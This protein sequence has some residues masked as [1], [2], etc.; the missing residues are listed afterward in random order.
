[1]PRKKIEDGLTNQQR[2]YR[3]HQAERRAKAR[4]KYQENKIQIA[5]IGK[6]DRKGWAPE[7]K[8]AVYLAGVKSMVHNRGVAGYRLFMI[9]CGAKRRAKLAGLPFNL[10]EADLGKPPVICPVLGIPIIYMEPHEGN[11]PQDNSPS[12]DRIKPALGYVRGNIRII[13][14]RANRLRNNA[15][16]EEARL[17]LQDHE[18]L[19]SLD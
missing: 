11:G 10:V 16:L 6:E 2:H 12:I 7:K 8:R 3:R 9:M 18:K 19:A 17:I 15:T 4:A 1:M 14:M 5:A 13:S